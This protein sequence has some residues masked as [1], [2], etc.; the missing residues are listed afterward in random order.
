M[1]KPVSPRK[2]S[3][4]NVARDAHFAK[5]GYRV[6]HITTGELADNLDGCIQTLLRELGLPMTSRL[7][8]SAAA[9]RAALAARG[10]DMID[11]PVIQPADP[12]L[13]MAGEDLR[14]R[15]FLTENETGESL[16]LRPEFTIPVC[17]EHI[18]SRAAT[19]HR[20]AYLGAVFRQRRDGANEFFQAGIEDLGD[21]DLTAADAR[22]L[23][24][25]L[26]VVAAAVPGRQLVTTM[27]DQ[28]V[29]EAVLAALGL[30]RGWQQRLARAFGMPDQLKAALADLAAG[31]KAA[32]ENGAVADLVLAGDRAAL[33]AHVRAT[34]AATGISPSAGRSP[35]EIAARLMEKA[36]L[37]S[38]RLA[39]GAMAALEAFLS[40][41]VPLSAAE[42]ALQT[43]AAKAGLSIGRA[44][45]TFSSRIAAITNLGLDPEAIRYDAAFGRPLDYYTGLVYEITVEGAP[46]PLAGGGRYDRL[47]TLLGAE[48]AIPGVGFSLWLDRAEAAGLRGAA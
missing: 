25:A 48:A 32:A 30:P 39:P 15:I 3:K 13:D 1:V 42:A 43:F 18:A 26:A 27:G 28:A 46:K 19:P 4:K 44:L 17:L 33:V 35:A 40:I 41:E 11:V 34:M 23:A 20:Y 2:A 5:L 7:P 10:T 16:C 9:I 22:S 31:G 37:A 21:A 47:L 24:D 14:R 6:L 38:T 12:F 8:S 45:E 29:F 36:E